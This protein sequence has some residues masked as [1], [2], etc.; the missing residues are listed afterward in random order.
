MCFIIIFNNQFC[1]DSAMELI[2]LARMC[3]CCERYFWSCF[4]GSH[5][6]RCLRCL[7]A[8]RAEPLVIFKAPLEFTFV[9]FSIYI[10]WSNSLLLL[11]SGNRALQLQTWVCQEEL[12][13]WPFG[14]WWGKG[15]SASSG[16]GLPQ[17]FVLTS[18]CCQT[19]V[20][21]FSAG[22]CTFWATHPLH[23]GHS[24]HRGP[25]SITMG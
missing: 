19:S 23:R 16:L 9:K 14:W 21:V 13:A 1:K 4:I 6:A 25:W 5:F 17:S 24:A 10:K 3:S 7:E 12:S 15:Q 22:Q 8:L 18:V 11:P 20:Q 2:F